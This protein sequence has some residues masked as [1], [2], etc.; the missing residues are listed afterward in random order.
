MAVYFVDSS[1]LAKRYVAE[2]GSAWIQGVLDPATGSVVIIARITSVE[3]ISAF[4]RRERAGSLLP[5]DAG[6]ARTDFRAHLGAE[7]Q[8]VEVD[9]HVLSTA[10]MLAESHGL[11]GYDAVQL[12]AAVVIDG[13]YR[14]AGL[15]PIMLLSSDS[16]LNAAAMA[17]VLAFDDPNTHQ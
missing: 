16:E 8:I 6:I 3:L 14:A 17:A 4:T 7:Y 5:A 9:E 12:A 1:A 2:I 11:R 10:M 15:R 13:Q